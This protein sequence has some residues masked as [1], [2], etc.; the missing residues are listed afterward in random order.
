MKSYEEIHALLLS[1]LENLNP[2]T[3]SDHRS[4]IKLMEQENNK[5]LAESNPTRKNVYLENL[6]T[7]MDTYENIA[8]IKV[9]LQKEAVK[10]T[11]SYDSYLNDELIGNDE[12]PSLNNRALVE[13]MLER[14][15]LES[16]LRN[17]DNIVHQIFRDT[18][19][20]WFDNNDVITSIR[21]FNLRFAEGSYLDEIAW[22]YGLS[23]K[24]DE[25]DEDLRKRI[26]A[27]FQEYYTIKHVQNSDVTFFTKVMGNPYQY[28]TSPNTY[29]RNDYFGY[30]DY[31]IENYWYHRYITWRDIIWL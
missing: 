18:I 5:Y 4:L 21:S 20:W 28:L 29:L 12:N 15:N 16:A 8:N 9:N 10:D 24:E 1:L 27:R 31:E 23:R 14:V 3:P 22:Q 11:P 30:S 6:N 17:P 2:E 26:L 7:Y 25:S 13:E 19:G